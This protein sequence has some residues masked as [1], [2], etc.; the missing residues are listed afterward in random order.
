MLNYRALFCFLTA[1]LV[2]SA[3]TVAVAYRY[4]N[5]SG[6]V[7]GS[8]V[9]S[10]SIAP[11]G[12]LAIVVSSSERTVHVYRDGVEIGISTA[13]VPAVSA[14]EA[15]VFVV[16]QVEGLDE[17]AS[18]PG[19]VWR[20]TQLYQSGASHG[21]EGLVGARLPDDFA[22][23]LMHATSRGAAVIVARERTGPQLFSAPG[24][25]VDPVETGS[26][27]RV[28]RFA[29]PEL[30]RQTIPPESPESQPQGIDSGS[31]AASVDNGGDR[32]GQMTSVIL[33]RADL[34][35]YVMKDGVIV[36]R[37]AI[38]V[39]DPTQPFGLHA[40]ML[41]SP[42]DASSEAK[43]L[44]FGIADE[45]GTDHIVND[46]AEQALR[47]VR[48]LDKERSKALARVMHAGSVVVLIDGHGPSVTEA[49]ILN[50][51]LLQS[52]DA[53]LSSSGGNSTSPVPSRVAP[54]GAAN[55]ADIA[56]DRK[57]RDR[58]QAAPPSSDI[59][60]GKKVRSASKPQG[61]TVTRRRGPLDHREDW[62][63]SIY[64]PY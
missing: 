29:R 5:Q 13:A 42:A 43:W 11:E 8:F 60:A 46:G 9:W 38:T 49:P 41:V 30:G 16:S 39:E 3:G 19:L 35:A 1:V 37:L 50:V 31:A 57:T 26:L 17:G 53:V 47:R 34:S 14:S 48:F 36:D 45:A 56:S 52:E 6:L 51:A 62:P 44:G 12:A 22:E 7:S 54:R 25:F 59:P 10:P 18:S 40:V 64:W 55:G 24:P 28:G 2:L 58:T 27:N 33:S 21:T 32:S 61:A 23:L 15:G 4:Q 63:N 20:G